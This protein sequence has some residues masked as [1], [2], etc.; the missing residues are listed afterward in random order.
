MS[1][2]SELNPYSELEERTYKFAEDC[3][4]FTLRL[5]KNL[6]N[7]EYSRQLIRSSGS[8]TANYI[9]ANEA[10]SGKDRCFRLK[11]CRKEVKESKIWLRLCIMNNEPLLN[12][13]RIR[14]AGESDELRRIFSRL[15]QLNS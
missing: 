2:K 5:P 8:Q 1:D 10:L 12:G 6:Q 13:E 7:F 9:E 11:I 3:R 14:L 15:I 4:N